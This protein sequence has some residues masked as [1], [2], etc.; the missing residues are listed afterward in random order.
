[1]ESIGL[2]TRRKFFRLGAQIF[3]GTVTAAV[4]GRA[5][6][7]AVSSDLSELS[8]TAASGAVRNGD[9]SAESYAAALLRRYETC[10][11]LNAFI[12]FDPVKVMEGARA[13]DKARAA[14]QLLGVLH[15]MPI[16]VKD[17]INTRALPT[18]AG[19]NGLRNFHPTTDAPVLARLLDEGAIL[20]GK[21]NMHELSFGGTSTNA[22]FGAVR[23][24]YD[25]SRIPG[26]SSGGTAA[27]VAARIAPAGLGEDTGGSIRVPAALCG[28]AGLRPTTGRY[29][30]DG[31]VPLA[32]T[33]DTAGPMARSVADLIVLDRV[34]SG[35]AS[36][37]ASSKLQGTRLALSRQYYFNDLDPAVE[38][39]MGEALAR[40]K[41]AGV[42]IVEA[43]IPRLA[44]LQGRIRRTGIAYEASRAIAEFLERYQ[45]PITFDALIASASPDVSNGLRAMGALPDSPNKPSDEAYDEAIHQLRPALQQIYRDYFREYN[46]SAIVFPAVRITAPKIAK[47][48]VSPAPDFEINGKIVPGGSA[49]GRNVGPTS[50]AGL[51]GLV[52]PAGLTPDGLPVGLEL[53]GAAENDSELLALGLAVEA[54]LGGIPAPNAS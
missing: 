9:I 19:T 28:V 23:N 8:L 51:P 54:A 14:G 17:S 34:M 40:L 33:F 25:P 46:V 38:R 15:G 37:A 20:F 31:I 18:T 3:G 36:T 24:P 22:A 21:T 49:L 43:E 42:T 4:A 39:V 11:H 52:I 41:D 53:D 16:V 1:M 10:R 30:A 48:F 5:W 44:E 2:I 35:N 26:G 12:S 6:A 29:P 50:T 32:P 13:A 7:Q 27:A 45:A 47:E